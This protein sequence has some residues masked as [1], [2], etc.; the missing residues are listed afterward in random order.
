MTYKH[1]ASI[2]DYLMSDQPYNKW[3]DYVKKIRN[4]LHHEGTRIL[5][6]GCGT[7]TLS[8]LLAQSGFQVTG[9][10]LSEE[11][12]AIAQAKKGTESIVFY[13]QNM[14]KLDLRQTFD[15]VVIFCDA[16]NYLHTKEETL[17]TLRRVCEHLTEGGL[18]MFDVHSVYKMEQLFCNQVYASND[19]EVAFIWQCFSGDE[20]L[21]VYHDLSFFV[22]NKKNSYDRFDELHYQKT[23]TIAEYKDFL[24]EA[25]FRLIDISSDFTYSTP[26]ET[27]ERIFFSAIKR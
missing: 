6:L 24:Y 9:V 23:Y 11:M 27:S 25:G 2:Y 12:L 22:K 16:L 17:E 26:T 8:L 3:V 7:G 19:E 20:P 18:L 21:S 15:V 1:F 13:H 10:D 14:T 5:D 4:D